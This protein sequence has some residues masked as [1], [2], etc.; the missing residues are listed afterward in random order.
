MKKALS[1]FTLLLLALHCLA[2]QS[3]TR[4]P[5][6]QVNNL[7]GNESPVRV[8]NVNID[9][10]V[11]GSLAVTTVEMTFYNPNNRI[12]EG[13]LQFPLAEGQNI[14]RF[15]LDINGRLREGVV[16]EKAKGQ[17]VFESIVRRG[18]DPGLLEKTQGNN[19]KTRVYPLF[20]KGTRKVL[21]AYEQE[22]PK[23]DDSYRF[24]L[25][26]EYGNVLD[27]FDLNISVFGEGLQPKVDK[28]PWGN[29]A[30]DR[31][32]DSYQ[33]SYSAQKYKAK[34]QLVFSVPVK[35]ESQTFVEKGA[36]SNETVFYSQVFPSIRS[37]SRQAPKRIALYWDASSSMDKRKFDL[38]SD[39][40]T[41]YL[42]EIG[43]VEVDLYTFN[44]I[45][46]KPQSFSIRNGNWGVLRST[47]EK[48]A[49]D[50]ATQLGV[51]NF[52]NTKA[53]E[54]LLFSDGLGNFG[55]LMPQ[56]GNTPVSVISS[57]LSA[58]HS[59]LKY[60]ASVTGGKHINLLQQAPM[61]AIKLLMNENFRLISTL[62]NK[63]EISDFTTSGIVIKPESG[64]SMA[65]K[66]KVSAATI[67][68]NFGIGN[69]IT[70]TETVR[71][72]SKSIGSYGNIVERV[73]A[74]KKIAELDLLFEK[75]KNEIEE[76]GKKYN[77]VTRNTSLIVL[78]DVNDYVRNKI[79]PPAELLEE[80]NRR[81]NQIQEDEKSDR[82]RQ[83]NRVIFLFNNRKIWW[84]KDFSN[85]AKP[86]PKPTPRPTPQPTPTQTLHPQQ[87]GSV[88]GVVVDN[89]GEPVIGATVMIKGTT[90]GTITDLDGKYY[91]NAKNG[92]ILVIS[93]LGYE[94]Q[95]VKVENK[96]ANA[97]LQESQQLLEEVV[98]TGYGT[99][100]R[101]DQVS[102]SV[103]AVSADALVTPAAPAAP[104]NKV[105]EALQ[106]KVSGVKITQRE[107]ES[108]STDMM[109]IRGTSSLSTGNNPLYIVDGV[110]T[111]N[112]PN[113]S[114]N[115]I[116]DMQ[117]M[118][119]A[120]ATSIYGSRAAD[121]IIIISTKRDARASVELK[122]W[123][124][125]APYIAEL[126]SKPDK[127]LYA[128][129]LA[130][131]EE[132]KTTP[133]FFL[134]VATLF[135]ERGLKE[136]ALIILSNLAE[137]EVENYRL[138][139]VLGYRLK[140]LG[141]N[142]YA[143]EQF[144]T[145]LRLRPEEPQSY[146]DLGATYAQNGQYQ[147]SV[148]ILYKILERSWDGRFPEIEV[149]AAEEMN[150]V[151]AE[152]GRRSVSLNL[153]NIDERL[154]YNM[155]VDIR[156]VLNWDTDNSDMDL[157]VTDPYGEKCYYKNRFTK[158]GGFMSRD[159]TGGYGPEEF[160]I[161]KAVKGKYKV[162]ANY[163]GSREQ[164]LVGPTT[165]YLDIYTYYASGREK[166]E[167]ITLR[168]SQNKEVVNVG[169]V[170]FE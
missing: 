71:I 13:E 162:Q 115:D 169:E 109:R 116:A 36:I 83:I 107:N 84:E 129:Y 119:D 26:I 103:S 117:V 17:E 133:S 20:A 93:Y 111:D 157:W 23:N 105:G 22:L 78:E 24:F 12:L 2:Q 77:I 15:A 89:I 45:L 148:D 112:I 114:P 3:E 156:I 97:I 122:K 135:E 168:L 41:A 163:Y 39:L 72:D 34:G 67:K 164:T 160:L 113:I 48:T 52:T 147:E 5:I 108:G 140:Q 165:I 81:V 28:T 18:V 144:K 8:S 49:Y 33:A 85:V 104:A 139:R 6:M 73:W 99:T 86:T 127:E 124:S 69:R 10:K 32:G 166:K 55:K 16:V 126:Q 31:A 25:P 95:A 79:V 58:D 145:V 170:M 96:T 82:E 11:V 57:S 30:F 27:K 159:F 142:E 158:V 80:Y 35:N 53:D 7:H 66:L 54:I 74:E 46:N 87:S 149:I 42:K 110:A 4:S 75:N 63:N 94:S 128:A 76:L 134:E 143:I 61:D 131:R 102:A 137:L 44:C 47:L 29:F 88:S 38:E 70:H 155:P 14:S 132:Y 60:I 92:D 90:T 138:L 19:F 152:A 40:L 136:E 59:M 130:I 64:F 1:L 68:L 43:N 51:L 65:G 125:N 121:G 21:I 106:G 120:S 56:T 154:I 118:K 153:L 146:R 9:V 167:T 150:Q 98:V 141:Y 161:K 50:G 100:R 62:Y 91:I 101:R 151:I 123:Q 37:E